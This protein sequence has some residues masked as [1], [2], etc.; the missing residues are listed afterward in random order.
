MLNQDRVAGKDIEQNEKVW[1]H[2]CEG[3]STLWG[4]ISDS[5]KRIKR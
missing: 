2:G 4:R 1:H 3:R 5:T